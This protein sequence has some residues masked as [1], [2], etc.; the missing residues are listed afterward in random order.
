[1][2]FCLEFKIL[3]TSTPLLEAPTLFVKQKVSSLCSFHP[4]FWSNRFR[5][6]GHCVC[7]RTLG[8]SYM[9][10]SPPRL[11]PTFRL[12]E[13]KDLDPLF[14]RI[15]KSRKIRC[16][17]K[18]TDVTPET[19]HPVRSPRKKSSRGPEDLFT[20]LQTPTPTPTESHV[21]VPVSTGRA[22]FE[23]TFTVLRLRRELTMPVTFSPVMGHKES[24][25]VPT[26]GL[27]CRRYLHTLRPSSL[28]SL[29]PH[30][31]VPTGVS[32]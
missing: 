3:N 27:L 16:R 8:G 14:S 32:L 12:E 26:R 2:N 11:S 6:K 7:S 13:V 19:L 1:M 29:F 10:H 23:W 5:G 28:R 20:P 18:H 31:E 25:R 15:E 9:E 4:V 17:I 21:S 30:W 24:L 22:L